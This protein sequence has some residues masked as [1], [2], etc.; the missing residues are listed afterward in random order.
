MQRMLRILL[1]LIL[2]CSGAAMHLLAES[3]SFLYL[4]DQRIVTVELADSKS[5]ILNYISLTSTYEILKARQLVLIGEGGVPYR[6]HLF[7]KEDG[8]PERPFDVSYL[9]KPNQFA[10][11]VVVGRFDV[12]GKIEKV[13]L[14]IG[15]RILELEAVSD[16]DFEVVAAR[17]GEINFESKDKKAAI[18]DSGFRRGFGQMAFAGSA[19]AEAYARYFSDSAV[20]A[21]VALETPLPRLPS[22]EAALPDPVVVSV[23][24][25]VSKTG[26]LKNVEAVDGP[27]ERLNR[28][29]AET[30]RNSWVFLPA[31]ADN[32]LAEAELKLNVRFRR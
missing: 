16:E 24:A 26:G 29:A 4:S 27:N 25:V 18:L 17:I 15:G 21:P 5:V 28:I 9:V 1:I 31:I 2:T 30:V 22:S 20:V 14:E 23:K 3:Q 6:G 8:G 19:E 12:Q 7:Q 11:Y 10:G 13:L 32:E